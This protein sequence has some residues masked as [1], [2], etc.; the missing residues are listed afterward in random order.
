MQ[1]NKVQEYH[2]DQWAKLESFLHKTGTLYRQNMLQDSSR[3]NYAIYTYSEHQI[4]GL[5]ISWHNS[6]HPYADY[7]TLILDPE[8]RNDQAAGL[9]LDEAIKRSAKSYLQVSIQQD[10]D[11][12]PEFY[13][14]RQFMEVRRTYTST[15]DIQEAI[16]AIPPTEYTEHYKA[17]SILNLRDWQQHDP[18]YS[19]LAQRVYDDYRRVHTINPPAPLDIRKWTELLQAD[20]IIQEGSYIAYSPHRDEI[21]GY[22]LMH[23]SEAENC[24]EL[25]WSDQGDTNGL[26]FSLVQQQLHHAWQQGY[27]CAEMEI[28]NTDPE[29][30]ELLTL[31]PFHS[32]PAL[33]TYQYRK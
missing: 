33:I 7:I 25:G 19:R 23:E 1:A 20:D 26:R 16:Q 4:N 10:G 9:L 15:L 5:L 13:K 28:D 18:D 17:L 29:R 2:S 8:D 24:V 27:V 31:L 14:S 22:A 11:P 6:F 32:S 3:R 21:R 30:M 12:E